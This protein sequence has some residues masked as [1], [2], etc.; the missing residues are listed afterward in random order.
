M[1]DCDYYEYDTFAQDIRSFWCDI[2][3]EF[4]FYSPDGVAA[5]ANVQEYHRV[6]RVP[7]RLV[8]HFLEW[9]VILA[10]VKN[11]S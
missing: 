8:L 2:A 7:K 6:L 4:H 5:D 11:T 1:H 3:V 9:V 10:R